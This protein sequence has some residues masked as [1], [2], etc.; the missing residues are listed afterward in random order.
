ALSPARSPRAG[1]DQ[2]ADAMHDERDLR[3]VP[4]APQGSADRQ[5][6]GGVLLLQPGPGT[7]PGRFHLPEPA[8]APERRAGKD[9]RA[10]D[11]SLAQEARRTSWLDLAGGAP[12][13]WR[14]FS[15]G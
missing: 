2:L 15:C 4:A 12:L 3:P 11:R 13:Q 5:G 1:I 14:V 9:R 7:R 8:P 6:I 10:M